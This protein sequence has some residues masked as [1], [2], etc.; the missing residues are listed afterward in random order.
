MAVVIRLEAIHKVYRLGQTEVPILKG[1]DLQIQ[2]GEYVAIMGPSGSGKSTLMNIIGC[3]DRPTKGSYWLNNYNVASLDSKALAQVRNQE[4]GFIFQQFNLLARSDALENVMLP[5]LYAGINAKERKLKATEMLERVGL[6]DRMHNLPSQLSG[7][8]QQRVAIA[9][10]LIN[11]P[12]ILLADEPTGALDT[13]TGQEV[14]NLFEE[15]H[16]E[17]LTL[18]VI[19]HD[20][21]VGAR[22]HR[23][24]RLRDGLVEDERERQSTPVEAG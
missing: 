20:L 9:R 5:A 3:L 23:L 1:I 12:S 16:L 6:A 22:A 14:L 11:R 7:G 2:R 19:T 8:Q 4:I 21:E 15:L 18:I 24:I 13:K 10:A 17:G